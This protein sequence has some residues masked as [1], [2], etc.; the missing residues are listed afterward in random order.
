M[1]H[2]GLFLSVLPFLKFPS[3]LNDSTKNTDRELCDFF[4][5]VEVGLIYCD[6]MADEGDAGANTGLRSIY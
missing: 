2:H 5:R 1:F 6:V 3:Q 4:I